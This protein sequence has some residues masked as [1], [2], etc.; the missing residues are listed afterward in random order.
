M[1]AYAGPIRSLGRL[2]VLCACP[3]SQPAGNV[4]AIHCSEARREYT[5]RMPF[6]CMVGLA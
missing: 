1:I 3:V 4:Y 5:A 2:S 6:S